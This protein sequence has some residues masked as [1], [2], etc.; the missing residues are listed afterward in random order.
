[1]KNNLYVIPTSLCDDAWDV[2]PGSV[3]KRVQHLRIFIVEND[4]SARH[5]LKMIIPDLPL[6]ECQFFILN[7]HT[8]FEEAESFLKEI[9]GDFGLLSEAGC[10]CVADPGA[11]IVRLAHERNINIIPLIGPSSILLALMASGLNGQ[12]FVFHGYL[13]KEKDKRLKKLR[14]MESISER[15]RQT[16]IFMETPYHNQSLFAEILT[17]CQSQTLFCVAVDLTASSEFVKTLRIEEW[18]KIPAPPLQ[19]RPTVFLLYKEDRLGNGHP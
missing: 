9:Q 3:V 14:N 17:T 7:E 5:F 13:P 15:E 1:M 16:Q 2:I 8:S 12:N 19:K 4:K 11:N 10:P 18:R 6:A